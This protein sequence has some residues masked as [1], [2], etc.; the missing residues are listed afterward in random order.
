MSSDTKVTI[1]LVV[2]CWVALSVTWHWF[3]S[4]LLLKQWARE[5]G[6]E[7][8]QMSM[9]WFK[10]NPFLFASKHQEVLRIKV[11]DNKG[12]ERGGWAK[13]GGFWLGFLVNKIEVKWD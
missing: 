9:N 1:V 4:R 10:F 6:F 12:R 2:L 11:R 5:N 13:C 7:L 3:R 8:M